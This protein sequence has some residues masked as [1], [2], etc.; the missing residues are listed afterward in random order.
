MAIVEAARQLASR[1]FF[2]IQRIGSTKPIS[3]NAALAKISA[4]VS[5]PRAR[6]GL[7]FP[8]RSANILY[9]ERF[10]LGELDGPVAASGASLRR[11]SNVSIRQRTTSAPAESR[12]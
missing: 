7:E 2:L 9:L 4:A 8:P 12:V 6:T 3:L 1:L 5:H 10:Q 11:L